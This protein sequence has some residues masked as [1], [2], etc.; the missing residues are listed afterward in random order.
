[1]T[2]RVKR[3]GGADDERQLQNISY[4]YIYH[5]SHNVR[6]PRYLSWF[7][8]PITMVY[9]TYN[10][11]VTGANLLTNVHIT[12]GGLTLQHVLTVW[13]RPS[14]DWPS[15]EA[16]APECHHPVESAMAISQAPTKIELPGKLGNSRKFHVFHGNFSSFDGLTPCT[17]WKIGNGEDHGR[18]GFDIR[19][20]TGRPQ[21][22]RPELG[23]KR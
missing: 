5:I 23:P 2:S 7:I 18:Y 8:T 1:M 16:H 17:S 4:I 6:P 3:S 9:G 11:L 22:F 13:T 12:T 19:P 15:V 21:R 20:E 10:E 14:L